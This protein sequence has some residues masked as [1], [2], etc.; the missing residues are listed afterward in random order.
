[1]ARVRFSADFDF[2]VT[3]TSLIAYTAGR[4]YT[5]KRAC[6]DLAVAQ[7]KAVEIDVPP[8]PA[9]PAAPKRRR[10]TKAVS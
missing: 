3:R 8:R 6:A 1:M 7:G 9:A 5:V 4:S 10:R 2:H